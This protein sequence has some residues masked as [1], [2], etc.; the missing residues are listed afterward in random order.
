MPTALRRLAVLAA[1]TTTVAGLLVPSAS[2]F[3]GA[4]IPGC[5]PAAGRL[6]TGTC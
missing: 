4:S 2:A 3:A 1:V 5:R 6:P